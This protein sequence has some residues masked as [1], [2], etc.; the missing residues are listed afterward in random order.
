MR[1]NFQLFGFEFGAILSGRKVLRNAVEGL[2]NRTTD[3]FYVLFLDYDDLEKSWVIDELKDIQ[4]ENLLSEIYLFETSTDKYSAVCFD[5]M[6]RDEYQAILSRSS[7]DPYYK[8]IPWT[9][10]KRVSTLRSS[11]KKGFVPKYAGTI[12]PLGTAY[13]ELSNAHI[14]F[15]Q[16]HMNL[17]VRSGGP[18]DDKKELIVAKYRI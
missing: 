17:K 15:F 10:G 2:T 9:F 7:C 14:L 12:A 13:R 4:K 18:R 5:K 1:F 16:G 8:K 11:A 3:G 6:T